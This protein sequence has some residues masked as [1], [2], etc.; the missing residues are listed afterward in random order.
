MVDAQRF[1]GP[2][3][4]MKIETVGKYLDAYSTALKNKA[5]RRVYIDAFAGS[6]DFVYAKKIDEHSL[7][8]DFVRSA[9]MHVGSARR[10]LS[11]VPRFDHLYFCDSS[12]LNTAAL[13]AL[14]VELG[15]SESATIISGEANSEVRKI[16]ADL[17]RL[18]RG[19]VFLDPFGNDV[20][21][22]TLVAIAETEKLDVWYLSPLA[23]IYRNAPRDHAA[24]TDEKRRSVTRILGSA[25][26]EDAFYAVDS[27]QGNLFTASNPNRRRTLDVDGI[28]RFVGQ[29]L[30]TIFPKVAHPRR[31]FGTAKKPMFSLFFA[32]SNPSVSAQ[33]LALKIAGDILKQAASGTRPKFGR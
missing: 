4:V 12:K 26:W 9:Q 21:W 3:S 8:F 31:L 5:F 18:D 28:E 15:A 10:A 23:G 19:V 27:A 20:A 7:E 22:E 2:W 17:S 29:R 14:V 1:G 30:S 16:C 33:R 6:G 11:V 25:A 32:I 13:K 24:L